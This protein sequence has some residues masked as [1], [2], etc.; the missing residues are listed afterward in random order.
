MASKEA[1][2]PLSEEELTKL[3]NLAIEAKASAY[4]PYSNFRVGACVLLSTGTYHTGSNVEV[5]STP[6]GI[7]AERCAIAP[8]V[9]SMKRPAMPTI[10][11]IAVSTDITPPASPCGMCRQF[12]NEFATTKDLPIFM[13]GKDGLDGEAV[14]MTIGELLPM[15]FG[16]NDI[17]RNR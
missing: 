9:A 2:M 10:R 8:I 3:A 7:C 14:K 1:L 15:S 5:A 11:A 17:E 4:C 16:P 6:V 12:I 13:Y